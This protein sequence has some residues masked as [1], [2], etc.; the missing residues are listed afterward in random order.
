MPARTLKNEVVEET[1]NA[2]VAVKANGR[3]LPWLG[4][5]ED[6]DPPQ[7]DD[8]G[9][10]Q[11]IGKPRFYIERNKLIGIYRGGSGISRR[12]WC[13]LKPPKPKNQNDVW[14]ISRARELKTFRERLKKAGI[15][16]A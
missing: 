1:P 16:G 13:N 3:Y 6:L 15:P 4:N 7:V 12:L 10:V 5:K 8:N 14:A 11:A 9:K 2:T